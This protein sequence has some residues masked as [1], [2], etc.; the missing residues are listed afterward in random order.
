M[1]LPKDDMRTRYLK[2]FNINNLL[3]LLLALMLIVLEAA[4]A[5]KPVQIS[6]TGIQWL[7][8]PDGM[9]S[10]RKTERRWNLYKK[11]SEC[12][13]IF[14]E[15]FVKGKAFQIAL[16]DKETFRILK[17]SRVFPV[18]QS[19]LTCHTIVPGPRVR[20]IVTVML[21]EAYGERQMSVD[22]SIAWFFSATSL[23]RHGDH[24]VR[25]KLTKGLAD[26]AQADALKSG[27]H[28]SWNPK[29]VDYQI[30]VLI[31]VLVTAFS[32]VQADLSASERMLVGEWLN[33]L[34]QEVGNSHWADRQDNKEYQKVL[35]GLIW[36][37]T[38]EDFEAVHYATDIYKQ[39]IH[40][41][42]P[43]GS[44]PMD[45]Q[46]GGMGLHYN[47]YSAGNLFSIAALL[48]SSKGIDLF[49]YN[50]DGRSIHTA[51]EFVIRSI[52]DPSLNQKY[53]ISCPHSGDRFGTIENPSIYFSQRDGER[54]LA[55][56]LLVYASFFPDSANAERI[57]NLYGKPWN[58][59]AFS[60]TLTGNVPCLFNLKNGSKLLTA[61]KKTTKKLVKMGRVESGEGYL[62]REVRVNMRLDEKSMPDHFSFALNVNFWGGHTEDAPNL[63]ALVFDHHMLPSIDLSKMKECGGY[64]WL[65]QEKKGRRRL[66]L[67]FNDRQSA[68]QCMYNS[69]D[70]RDQKVVRYL[71]D[72]IEEIVTKGTK[73][74]SDAAYWKGIT[75]IIKSGASMVVG[76]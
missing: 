48:K 60:E 13:Q 47:N 36:A 44:F 22:E 18:A 42:R 66:T 21:N 7:S 30:I 32:E 8:M 38:V 1:P 24:Q 49:S 34:V 73:G 54:F 75:T 69:L 51:I 5:K 2:V 16:L 52:E 67:P 63:V 46:R 11:A 10:E 70:E 9:L 57:R 59:P 39:A 28:V 62:W 65:A 45:S 40:D 14:D 23:A 58:Y 25:I 41:M 50:V 26:W 4:C 27:I 72:Q 61:S 55:A 53:A 6:K 43:D 15:T 33:R 12:L 20:P 19:N 3:V 37:L 56:Y 29:P 74:Q 76:Q 31:G 35:I 17:T 68:S 71:V 64:R